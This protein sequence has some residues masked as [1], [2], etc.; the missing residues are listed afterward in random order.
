MNLVIPSTLY[1]HSCT[2]ILGLELET[3]SI[4][5]FASSCV[6]MGRFLMQTQ[7]LSWS[8]G[9]CYIHIRSLISESST[10]RKWITYRLH[11]RNVFLLLL[12]KSLKIDIN[13]DSH[14]LIVG[15]SLTPLLLRFLH[16]LSSFLSV[17][18]NLLNL[19]KTRWFLGCSLSYSL[20]CWCWL[21]NCLTSESISRV[22]LS[23]SCTLTPESTS[24]S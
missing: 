19:A 5:P 2:V 7:I 10:V 4:S 21:S 20:C 9:I 18:L 8:A 3:T 14:R 6:K 15:S 13:F 22:L 23:T 16:T 17:H 12:D 24:N 11:E 1:L